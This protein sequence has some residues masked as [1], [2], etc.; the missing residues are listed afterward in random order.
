MHP[1][2]Q[3]TPR[4]WH[5]DNPLCGDVKTQ[6]IFWKAFG[7][8]TRIPVSVAELCLVQFWKECSA[9][10]RLTFLS[11]SLR[12]ETP[13]FNLDSF[14]L[15]ESIWQKKPTTYHLTKQTR[16]DIHPTDMVFFFRGGGLNF[17]SENDTSRNLLT[18][19]CT[20][21]TTWRHPSVSLAK[22]KR[23][24]S[25]CLFQLPIHV[26]IWEGKNRNSLEGKSFRFYL[27]RKLL[28]DFYSYLIQAEWIETPTLPRPQQPARDLLWA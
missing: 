12:G 1:Y 10:V 6:E 15:L 5:R 27:K 14:V 17:R 22:Q 13:H 7:V 23:W 8:T 9:Q 20:R 25:K 21:S 26:S 3:Y 19:D 2:P 4:C 28:L 11:V 18:K 24:T 16:F